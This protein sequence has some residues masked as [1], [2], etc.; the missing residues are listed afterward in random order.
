MFL[1]RVLVL[2]TGRLACVSAEHPFVEFANPIPKCKQRQYRTEIEIL[3][4]A[5]REIEPIM[6]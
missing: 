5:L 1:K 4:L 6:R 3:F 2:N